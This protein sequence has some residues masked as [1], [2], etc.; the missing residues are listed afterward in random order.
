MSKKG[1]TRNNPALAF[2]SSSE[3]EQEAPQ[4]ATSASD[5]V[6]EGYKLNPLYV[7]VKSKRVQLLVQ[8]STL[9][10]I[11]SIAKEKGISVNEAVNNAMKDYIKKEG[12]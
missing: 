3:P 8:P 1:F 7:E 2:I 9:E 11:K 5:E 10:A 12:K 4:T 6:P